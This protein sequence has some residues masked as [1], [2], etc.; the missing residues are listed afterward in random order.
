MS[1]C[2]SI[3]PTG[4]KWKSR[5]REDSWFSSGKDI[6]LYLSVCLSVFC[7]TV[8]L[9]CQSDLSRDRETG[10]TL[11]SHVVRIYFCVYLSVCLFIFF[12]HCLSLSLNLSVSE[13]CRLGQSRN[14]ET[15]RTRGSHVVRMYVLSVS[16]C[17]FVSCIVCIC[18]CLPV[19]FANRVKAE[20]ASQ[21]G[22]LDLTW[23]EDI[24]V[25]VCMF[26]HFLNFET[27][28]R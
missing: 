5:D 13:L 6:F 15:G 25:S 17:S 23:Y 14:C 16:V 7:L 3:L 26:V 27:G 11:G 10:R 8:C 22:L 24:F 2:L 28:R 12:L 1:V 21:I 20:I 4:S 9:F 19:D 18:I